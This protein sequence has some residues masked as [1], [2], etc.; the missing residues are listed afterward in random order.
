[1]GFTEDYDI[2]Y[3]QE[4]E[5]RHGRLA[6]LAAA[7]WPLSEMLAP[8]FMLQDGGRAPSVLNG[9]NPISAIA[10][11]GMFAAF[12][13]AE[14]TTALRRTADTELG[15]KHRKDMEQVWEFGVAVCLESTRFCLI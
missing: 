1:M 13:Y 8:N 5:L 14:Y 12:G 6:M 10:V 4:C 2:Y 9:F 15:R 7:G 3:M 11:L